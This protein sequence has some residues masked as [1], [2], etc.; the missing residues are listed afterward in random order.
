MSMSK[1]VYLRVHIYFYSTIRSLPLLLR[2]WQYPS[3]VSV[4][5]DIT[6][7]EPVTELSEA[8]FGQCYEVAEVQRQDA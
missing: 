5:E 1:W 8:W 3:F 7:L 4:T 6:K 2:R